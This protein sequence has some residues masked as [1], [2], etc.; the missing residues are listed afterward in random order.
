MSFLINSYRFGGSIPTDNLILYL[1]LNDTTDRAG[2]FTATQSNT[3]ATN[4]IYSGVASEAK[5]FPVNSSYVDIPDDDLLSFGDGSTDS[6]FSVS[7]GIEFNAFNTGRRISAKRGD[8]SSALVN[9]EYDLAIIDTGGSVF[10]IQMVL[11]DDSS[12]GNIKTIT[13]TGGLSTG[14]PYHFVFTYDGSSSETGLKWYIDGV[15][16][17]SNNSLNGSYTA[18]EN[19]SSSFRLGKPNWTANSVDMYLDGFGIWNIELAPEEV[20]AIYDKQSAG[21]E[22]L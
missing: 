16:D 12:S 3:L 13:N 21:N 5:D 14:V 18:M 4:G 8:G 22:I 1:R 6:A 11:V 19:L 2:N 7:F 15:L 17:S 20:T 9:Q 10:E